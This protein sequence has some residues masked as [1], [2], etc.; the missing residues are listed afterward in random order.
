M[1]EDCGA[2]LKVVGIV[3][4]GVGAGAEVFGGTE[5]AGAAE[6]EVPDPKLNPVVANE[7]VGLSAAGAAPNVG[8]SAEVAPNVGF[9]AVA[10]VEAPNAVGFSAFD[11]GFEVELPKVVVP[12]N[13]GKEVLANPPNPKVEE[14][15]PNGIS[16][17]TFVGAPKSKGF[18]SGGGV[19]LLLGVG[20]FLEVCA[21]SSSSSSSVTSA[22]PSSYS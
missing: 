21:P 16:G 6:V 1:S 3:K 22:L 4:T 13:W 14:V 20:F 12:P 2:K 7:N 8:F 11:S 15:S 5:N 17:V 18:T 9:S 10:K 19:F